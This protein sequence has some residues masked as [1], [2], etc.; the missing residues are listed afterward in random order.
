[1]AHRW[2]DH[3]LKDKTYDLHEVHDAGILEMGEGNRANL[4][5]LIKVYESLQKLNA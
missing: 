2:A 3:V 5:F 4:P 1:M